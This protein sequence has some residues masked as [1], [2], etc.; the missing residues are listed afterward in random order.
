RIACA[1]SS[2]LVLNLPQDYGILPFASPSSATIGSLWVCPVVFRHLEHRYEDETALVQGT[3]RLVRGLQVRLS[4]KKGLHTI[5]SCA[6]RSA[7]SSRGSSYSYRVWS[8]SSSLG[9]S[10]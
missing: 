8:Q 1:N 4:I 3:L 9:R 10:H 5:R 7:A 6:G 2:I